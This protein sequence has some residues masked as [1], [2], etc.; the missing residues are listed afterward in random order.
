M[1]KDALWPRLREPFFDGHCFLRL[2]ATRLKD[3]HFSHQGHPGDAMYLYSMTRHLSKIF[4]DILIVRGKLPRTKL[5]GILSPG[6][7]ITR[8]GILAGWNPA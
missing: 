2:A 5:E 3:L 6:F 7:A 1:R 8:H 4:E